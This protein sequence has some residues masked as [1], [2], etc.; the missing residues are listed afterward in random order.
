MPELGA[1]T[2]TYYLWFSPNQLRDDG[3][4]H[5]LLAPS[6]LITEHLITSLRGA[7]VR[8]KCADGP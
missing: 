8:S 7:I 3:K 4:P 1:E 6:V 5:A 2:T